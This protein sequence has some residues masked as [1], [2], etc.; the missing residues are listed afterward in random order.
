[1][2]SEALTQQVRAWI[3][4]DVDPDAAAEL[5]TLADAADDGDADAAAEL[6]D[7]FAAPLTFG[8]A[9]LRG[10]LRAG[11]NGMNRTVVRR[12]SAGIAAWLTE[13]GG[14]GAVVV[15]GHDA[16][17]GSAVFAADAAGVFAAAGFDVRLLPGEVPT[18][19]LAFA[20]KALGAEVGVMVTASHNPARDNGY[21][22]YG[23]DGAQIV[24]PTDGEIEAAIRAIGPSRDLAQ[25]D[26]LTRLDKGIVAAY[27]EAVAGLV[28]PPA[29]PIRIVHTAMHGVGTAVLAQVF[30]RAGYARPISVPEQAEPDP[31]FPTVAFPN[32]EEKGALDLAL[33]L[34]RAESA[35]LVVASDPDADRCAIAVAF[36]SPDG[37]HWRALTGD[38]LGALLADHLMRAGRTGTYATTIVSSTLLAKMARARGFPYVATLTG[39]KWITRA[40]ADLVFGYEEALGYAVAPGLVRD[41]DGISAGLLAAELTAQLRAHGSSIP[42]RLEEIAAEF[43]RHATAQISI[44]VDDLSRIDETMRRL[45]AQPPTRLRG[46]G[47]TVTD[48][49]PA[50]DVLTFAY[51]GGR[52]VVRPSGTEPKLKAYLEVVSTADAASAATE[53]K[54][55]QSE[56]SALLGV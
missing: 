15:I 4:D 18:P 43:G 10:P 53:L 11:P 36:P 51:D 3:A 54:R 38:E 14:A 21:K 55:L 6:G 49:S 1:M 32:P 52:V 13:R 19:V 34:A 5:T 47:V 37:P 40:A 35:D 30:A 50:A 56:V 2:S 25:S 39:F 31:D 45:R 41:K 7:R 8:T 20:V 9:G 12:T 22:V 26:R 17:H 48:L 33:A 23:A 16:R 27:V 42:Q 46:H 44:R 28:S 29:Q 24:P